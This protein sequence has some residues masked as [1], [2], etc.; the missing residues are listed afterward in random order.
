MLYKNFVNDT[1]KLFYKE[2]ERKCLFL[3]GLNHAA[4]IIKEMFRYGV[5]WSVE[6]ILDNDEK[7]SYVKF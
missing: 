7:W 1:W 2:R 4:F 6:A 3:F 5:E